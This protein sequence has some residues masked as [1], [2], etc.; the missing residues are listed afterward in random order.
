MSS[1]LLLLLSLCFGLA[2]NPIVG[3]E[4]TTYDVGVSRVD[5]TPDYPIRLNGFASRKSESTG[6]SSPI[7]A[8]AIAISQGSTPPLLL[9][10]VDSLGVRLP[11]VDALAA[12]LKKQF[13]IPRE[14]VA[15]SFTHT[16]SAPKVNGASDN[17]FAEPIPAAHQTH[18]DRYTDELARHLERAAVEALKNRR[19]STLSWGSGTVE[20]AKNRRT[21]GGPVDH[22]L[23]V[24]VATNVMSGKVSAVYVS[25]AC[26]CVT[27]SANK[28]DGDWAGYAANLVEREFP[29]SV[30][31]VSIGAG[32]DQNPDSGV[33]GDKTDI[34]QSQ[35][36]Q[37]A[38][39]VRRLVATKLRALSG[40]P[41][42]VYRTI[43]IALAALPTR[44]EWKA[45]EAKGGAA[46]YNAST[47]LARLDRGEKLLEAIDYPIQTW[48]WGED[49]CMLFLA[50]EVCVD[51]SIRLKSEFDASRIW[52]NGYCNDF[53]VYIPSERLL[54]EGGYGGGAEIPYFAL[55]TTLRPGLEQQIVDEA[56][57]QIP[58][59]FVVPPGTNGIPALSP[60]LSR[61]SL[62]THDDL[63]VELVAAEPLV[64][65]PVAIDFGTDGR[66]WVAEMSDYGRGVYEEFKGTGRVR[67]LKDVDRD[68]QFDE[69]TTFV[70]GLRFPTDVKCWRDGIL[71]CD[72]PKV[73]FAKDTNN[74]GVADSVEVLL[75]GFEV[76]NAQARVNSLRWGLDNY[77]YGSCGLFG[78]VITSRKTGETVEASSRDFRFDPDTGFFEPATGR[79]QQGRCRNDWGD[80][81]GCSNGTLIKYYPTDDRMYRNP[82]VRPPASESAV[83]TAPGASELRTSHEQIRF[84]LSGPPGRPTSGC[85]LGIYRDKRL[86]EEYYGNSFTCEPVHQC[87]HRLI[88]EET[89][90][91]YWGRRPENEQD[92]EFLWSQDR[93]FRPVQVR[94]GPDGAL[95][96]VDM[97]RFV[98]EHSRWIPQETLADLDVLAGQRRGRIY[99]VLPKKPNSV[100]DFD[101]S[102][103]EGLSAPELAKLL[104]HPNGTVRDMCHQRLVWI[105]AE[106]ETAAATNKAATNKAATNKIVRMVATENSNAAVRLQALATLHGLKQANRSDLLA[107]LSDKH[108]AVVR[109]AVRIAAPQIS[110]P[111]VLDRIVALQQH[112]DRRVRHAVAFV[113][114]QTKAPAAIEGLV[115][116]A[117]NHSDDPTLQA[118]I[119][120]SLRRET[121]NEIAGKILALPS[122]ERNSPAVRQL[123]SLTVRTGDASTC[124]DVLT[125]FVAE[126]APLNTRLRD[127]SDLLEAADQSGIQLSPADQKRLRMPFAALWRLAKEILAEPSL[128]EGRA[129]SD[130][131]HALQLIG[132]PHGKVS[133]SILPTRA[134]SGHLKIMGDLIRAKNTLNVQRAAVA[135]LAKSPSEQAGEQLLDAIPQVGVQVSNEILGV[136]LS[137][138]NWVSLLF[139]RFEDKRLAVNLLDASRR[140]M[141]LTHAN[142]KL[143]S[144][145]ATL[146]ADP[147]NSDRVAVIETYKAALGKQVDVEHGKLMFRKACANCHRLENWG[148][149]VGPDLRAL[150]NR[151]G[152]ALLVAALDPNREVDARYV[153]WVV[154]LEDGRTKTGILVEESATAIRLLEA[155]GKETTILRGDI[156]ELRSSQKSLMPDGVEKDL[157]PRDLACIIA[158]LRN[159]E[160]PYKQFAG[161]SP[162][163]VT[164]EGG[165]YRLTAPKGELRGPNIL[166]EEPFQ[167]VGYW[168]AESDHVAWKLDVDKPGKYDI[169]IDWSCAEAS[170][171][172][173]YQLD[174]AGEQLRG[175]VPGTGGWDRYRQLQIGQVDLS[176]SS[177]RLV[178][179]P[180]VPVRQA[181][182]DLREVRLVPTGQRA[183]FATNSS[184]NDDLPRYPPQIA[185]F[186]LDDSQSMEQRLKVI[187]VR[188]G[189]GP[190]IIRLLVVDLKPAHFGT[191][192]E[193]RRIPW[194]WRVAI[195]CGKRNDGGELRDLLEICLPGP[196]EPL[197][198]W[199]AVVV[200]G[201][202]INGL[203]QVD[204]WPRERIA[205][206]LRGDPEIE[207]RWPR[208]L[209][210]SVAM[211]D[212]TKVRSGTRYDA[213]RMVAMLP[214]ED[215]HVQ[216]ER[217]LKEGPRE[218][219]MGA[220]SGL[221]DIQHEGVTQVFVE[222]LGH[223]EG[224][225][226]ELAVQA[227]ERRKE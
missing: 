81:F 87:I 185:P 32:S 114:G 222:A 160:T 223:L 94:T 179:S 130:V 43:P 23:P 126:S 106:D 137:R 104:A 124:S 121:A 184:P 155:E 150:S 132:R 177:H 212:D 176:A 29:D 200:G 193:Y 144:R 35:G 196:T 6:V 216:L 112:D 182:F 10:T 141:L 44:K 175:T 89:A 100:S 52:V 9:L 25:Y 118:T 207:K 21:P 202:I 42:A 161:N 183:T 48:T 88:L 159:L 101:W 75:D 63:R 213:L 55:P 79:T 78:G 113:L 59:S 13:N 49:L 20:F 154:A 12:K 147:V 165:V 83:A 186:L 45:M 214:W 143:R 108:P 209:K 65:D 41:A 194:I 195:A 215:C 96:I 38:D 71:I 56:H 173:R 198:D 102:Q 3:A 133:Q 172:N 204:V 146:L 226:R 103:I 227:L 16:H 168:H 40:P 128:T 140:Q 92:H 151:N 192:E 110:D 70:D 225:N 17:I 107:A 120:S 152:S 187:D 24:L 156:D 119:Q 201:G 95:W 27:L 219:Q 76:R 197:R 53:C 30:A 134:G 166:F 218:L 129:E 162:A 220:V 91:G 163:V 72:A 58:K 61:Q 105:A 122:K 2:A 217:Y 203:T 164:S 157:S 66:L 90:T 22:S 169:Y 136:V 188:P 1:R 98:I 174:I 34:A 93:W 7:Y 18:I 82:L 135:A 57:R 51:Y 210:L 31:L 69:A 97:Y 153:S 189:M 211:A 14:N 47:Q 62:K 64:T 8:R 26:H 139:T 123:L 145:A 50:G 167:N 206:I 148:H 68:G 199:Q 208:T 77:L 171:G 205:G 127:L 39:E 4:A 181:L 158:Y 221:G 99:R 60:D 109:R 19:P 73:L 54:K 111:S 15:L 86:G 178:V 115:A 46:G 5:I 36:A 224:R 116:M 180:A 67:W 125:T 131:L 84:E 74:D 33:T 149:I 37:I 28:I 190:A 142:S 85:G 138:E 11:M 80:W 191:D 117:S 170:A